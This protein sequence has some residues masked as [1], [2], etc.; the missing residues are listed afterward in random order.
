[1]RHNSVI[2][3]IGERTTQLKIKTELNDLN[4]GKHQFTL[5]NRKMIDKDRTNNNQ[6]LVKAVKIYVQM[7]T[8]NHE[9]LELKVGEVCK[10]EVIVTPS[11]ETYDQV[12][13]MSTSEDILTVNKDGIVTAVNQ[14]VAVIL[15]TV[16]DKT[17]GCYVV[18]N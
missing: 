18:V 2:N 6:A 12:F 8:L 9:E 3:S 5:T 11:N 14:G 10:L 17:I 15:V 16:A 1:M 13:F 4:E 7:L